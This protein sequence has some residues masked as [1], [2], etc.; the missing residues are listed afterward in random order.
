MSKL[1]VP[2][3]QTNSTSLSQSSVG[4]AGAEAEAKAAHTTVHGLGPG[5]PGTGMSA[6]A[7]ALHVSRE[8][9]AAIKVQCRWR[10]RQ[11]KFAVYLKRRAK[12]Q[13]A[14]EEKVEREIEEAQRG[15]TLVIFCLAL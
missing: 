2:L 12:T 13:T 1:L 5:Q 14:L 8:Q 9:A 3:G 6:R 7:K 11:G 4:A 15:K 10:I